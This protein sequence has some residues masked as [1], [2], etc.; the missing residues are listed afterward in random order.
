MSAV[1]AADHHDLDQLLDENLA[2]GQEDQENLAVPAPPANPAQGSSD[3]NEGLDLGPAGAPEGARA[4]VKKAWRTDAGKQRQ[5]ASKN[6]KT[7]WESMAKTKGP[8]IA[9]RAPKAFVLLVT[10]TRCGEDGSRH[11]GV[12]GQGSGR[13]LGLCSDGQSTK[14]DALDGM[15][16]DLFGEDTARAG[17]AWQLVE[18]H[19]EYVSRTS[20]L[21][22]PPVFQ[23][24]VRAPAKKRRHG[25]SSHSR[26]L[27]ASGGQAAG[28]AHSDVA[29]LLEAGALVNSNLWGGGVSPAGMYG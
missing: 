6:I 27:L 7:L 12:W 8:R 14:G 29:G 16:E 5:L 26:S 19:A 11:I 4:S 20:D 23:A 21:Q 1:A 9:A 15:L 10:D 25:C 24:T 28:I 3:S 2:N 22:Q 17:H 18:Q 13:I